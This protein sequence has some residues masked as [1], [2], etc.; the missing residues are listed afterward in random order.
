MPSRVSAAPCWAP[1][2]DDAS[3]RY[4]A[5]S[6]SSAGVGE[7]GSSSQRDTSRS[8]RR[9]GGGGQQQAGQQLLGGR[10]PDV[11][12]AVVIDVRTKWL[13]S[14]W[15]ASTL[16]S[17]ASGFHHQRC[18]A[19][20][21]RCG[22]N[23]HTAEPGAARSSAVAAHRSALIAGRDDRAGRGQHVRDA[24]AGGLAAARAHERDQR[25]FPGGV[26]VR[27][28]PA[29]LLETAEHQPDVGRGE[30]AG[31]GAGQ[32]GPQPD[33]LPGGRGLR[34]L[35]D[36]PVPAE[37]GDRVAGPGDAA[38]D[39]PPRDD[40]DGGQDGGQ[41]GAGRGDQGC[42]GTGPGLRGAAVQQGRHPAGR[43]TAGHGGPPARAAASRAAAH[44]S[45]A[46]P[47]SPQKIDDQRP[48]ERGVAGGERGPR[49]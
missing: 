3:A 31:P 11:A 14:R 17:A 19:A 46:R 33:A 20:V 6:S 8:V 7:P 49:P 2:S 23:T 30:P 18:P 48:R 1:R 24:E 45:Q 37:R 15:A 28:V 36:R 32:R 4:P 22:S 16:V 9:G 38:G 26:Q 25:V 44:A 35:A 41:D 34:E 5:S 40:R 13:A 42:R 39:D 47:A 27:A 21:M 12:L 10:P 43:R 29:R